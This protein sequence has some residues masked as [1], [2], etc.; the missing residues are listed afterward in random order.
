M[1][2]VERLSA[3]YRSNRSRYEAFTARLE[4]LVCVILETHDIE[5]FAIDPRTKTQES[6]DK[7]IRREEKAGRYDVFGDVTDLS[8]IRIIAY[9]QEDC[10]KICSIIADNFDVD[11]KNS[12]IKE[13]ELAPDQVG[14][15]STHY[16]VKL[17]RARTRLPEFKQ[18]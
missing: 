9:L 15:L 16:V 8:G 13:D 17:N 12:V 7:K 1:V 4:A 2:D 6:F 5:V 18:F 14:Y 10:S 11:V 3:D